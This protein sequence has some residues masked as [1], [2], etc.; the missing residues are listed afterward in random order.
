MKLDNLN[1][2]EQMESFLKGSQAI[3][4]AVASSKDERYHLVEQ[5]LRRFAYPRLKR[6]EKGIVIQFFIKV[7]FYS[8]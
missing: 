2:L 5:I 8:R 7:S 1:T 4:F 3:A 6:R